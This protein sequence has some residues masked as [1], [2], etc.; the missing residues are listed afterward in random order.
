VWRRFDGHAF[1]RKMIEEDAAIGRILM[2]LQRGSGLQRFF[3]LTAERP[4]FLQ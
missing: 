3:W 4:Q 1:A 2:G